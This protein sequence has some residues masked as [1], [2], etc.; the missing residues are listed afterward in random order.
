MP[1]AQRDVTRS[2]PRRTRS[3]ADAAHRLRVIPQFQ[4]VDP[5]L[6]PAGTRLPHEG[7]ALHRKHDIELQLDVPA[8]LLPR[9][10]SGESDLG[11]LPRRGLFPQSHDTAV[12]RARRRASPARGRR[13]LSGCTAACPSKQITAVHADTDSHTSVALLRVLLDALHGLRPPLIHFDA[14]HQHRRRP[15]ARPDPARRRRCC[16]SA[17]RS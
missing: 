7:N 11:A 4:A 3:T 16:S 10:E 9:L 5:R 13:S 15:T 12:A 2:R 14:Q 8:R 17:T 1:E 6:C